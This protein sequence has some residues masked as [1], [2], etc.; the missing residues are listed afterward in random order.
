MRVIVEVDA[1]PLEAYLNGV[2]AELQRSSEFGRELLEAD[3]EDKAIWIYPTNNLL[4][5]LKIL[6]VWPLDKDASD[7]IHVRLELRPVDI[8]KK[9]AEIRRF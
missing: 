9:E 6:E 1:S 4:K 8:W 2:L 5:A 3:L 7:A